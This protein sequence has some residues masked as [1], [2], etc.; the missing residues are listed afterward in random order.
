MV[1]QFKLSKVY[2]SRLLHPDLRIEVIPIVVGLLDD[3]IVSKF[4]I[5]EVLVVFKYDKVPVQ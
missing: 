5:S 2:L 4:H 1:L 3:S